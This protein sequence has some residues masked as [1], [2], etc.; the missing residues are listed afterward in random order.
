MCSRA[1]L[2]G[3]AAGSPPV[4]VRLLIEGE[5]EPGSPHLPRLP[6]DNRE[7]LREPSCPARRA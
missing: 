1:D 7:R 2:A 6:E 3:R 4:T 5:E